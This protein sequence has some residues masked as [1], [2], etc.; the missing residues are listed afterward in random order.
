MSGVSEG[1]TEPASQRE[2]DG[3]NQSRTIE[4]QLPTGKDGVTAAESNSG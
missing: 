3:V 4:S 1:E 2:R